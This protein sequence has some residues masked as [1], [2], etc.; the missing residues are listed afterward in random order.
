MPSQTTGKAKNLKK[1]K[2]RKDAKP[3]HWEGQK[4]KKKKNTENEA[5]LC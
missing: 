4:K 1:K 2:N 3:D 5:P